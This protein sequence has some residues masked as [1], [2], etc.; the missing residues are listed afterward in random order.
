MVRSWANLLPSLAEPLWDTSAVLSN[1]SILGVLLHGLVGYVARPAGMQV[2]C[3]VLVLLAIVT[4][5]RWAKRPLH[6][7]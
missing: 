6:P 1:D 2:L 4:G 7:A 3:Y 5:M